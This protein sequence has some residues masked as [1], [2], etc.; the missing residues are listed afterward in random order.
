MVDVLGHVAMGL[1]WA[2]PAWAF[3]GRRLSLAF[4]GTVLL[5]VMVPDIDLYLPGVVHHGLTH[6]VLFVAIVA[7]LGGAVL[8]PLAGPTLRRWWRRREGGVPSS[9]TLYLFVAGGLLL[10]GLSH[11]F[12]DMLSAG[13]GGNPPLE[14]LW[15]FV[16]RSISIDFIYYSAFVWNGGLLAAALAIHLVLYAFDTADT[17][18]PKR[19]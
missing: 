8:A 11:L 17:E 10:G 12:I 5:T 7:L 3:S 13:S 14:P 19:T 1:L 2:V 15:P 16:V 9:T 4:V 18:R 6:T